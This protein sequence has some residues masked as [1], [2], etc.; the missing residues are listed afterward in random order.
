MKIDFTPRAM[1]FAQWPAGVGCIACRGNSC[2]EP[3]W[4]TTADIVRARSRTGRHD[5]GD[6]AYADLMMV[7]RR[8]VGA[9]LLFGNMGYSVRWLVG[10]TIVMAA[11][12]EVVLHA[13]VRLNAAAGQ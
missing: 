10:S 7:D 9:P 2:P 4:W 11:C 13:V 5:H 1:A 3:A 6:G 12:A 8:R